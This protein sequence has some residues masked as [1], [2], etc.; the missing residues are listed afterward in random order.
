MRLPPF[1]PIPIAG[2]RSLTAAEEPTRRIRFIF[3]EQYDLGIA[4]NHGRNLGVPRRGP[5]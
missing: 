4:G 3:D 5:S 1:S 2:V